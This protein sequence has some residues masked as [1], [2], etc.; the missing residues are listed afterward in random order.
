MTVHMPDVGRYYEDFQVGDVYKHWPGRTITETDNIW[1]TCL[2]MNSHPIHL[3]SHYA[4]GQMFGRPLVN[5]TLTLA[6]VVGMSVRDTSQ[7]TIANLGWE[8]ITLPNPVFAGD[9]LYAE[10]EVLAKRESRSRPS[11]GII[12]IRTTGYN[13]RNEVV[14][15]YRRS[16]LAKKRGYDDGRLPAFGV[17]P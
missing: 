9:T 2:T 5:S 12:T 1:F 14:I 13:Q 4:A 3:D 8:E 11:A 16:F 17:Q 6:M 15:T 10:S 7:N